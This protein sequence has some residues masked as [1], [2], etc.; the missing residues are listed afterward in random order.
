MARTSG[1][2]STIASSFSFLETLRTIGFS[3]TR[4][5]KSSPLLDA[6]TRRFCAKMVARDQPDG[7]LV[8]WV[9]ISSQRVG[10]VERSDTHQF[11]CPL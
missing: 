9:E 8:A 6:A 1:A 4:L 5:R 7:A 10:W 3:L 2:E 11:Q